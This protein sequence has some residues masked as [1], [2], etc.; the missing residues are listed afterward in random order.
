M[1]EMLWHYALNGA[2]TNKNAGYSMWGFGKK[3]DGITYFIKQFLTPK[4][5][6]NGKESSPERISKKIQ[7]CERFVEQKKA[8]YDALNTNSDGNAVRVREF[9]RVETRF[10]IAM[11]KVDALSWTIDT[12]A[13]LPAEETRRLCTIIAHAI[14][15]LHKGGLIHADLKHDNILYTKTA[16]GTVTAKVIDFDSSFLESAPPAASEEVVGDFNYFAPEV[17]ARAYGEDAKLTRKMDVFALGVLFHQYFSGL[18]PQFDREAFSCPG[19]A[20]LRGCPLR[21]H[22]S[23]PKE[24]AQLIAAMLEKDPAN[25]PTAWDVFTNLCPAPSGSAFVH[26]PKV[27]PQ[28]HKDPFKKAGDLL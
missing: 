4:F 16:G 20:V 8:V 10:Y 11:D 6:T 3:K 26:L 12:I 18:L 14:A 23:I 17:C 24:T 27:S 22:T 9:F 21:V 2:L 13:A 7:Q 25:R 5:P 15:G 19:E 28:I 1:M